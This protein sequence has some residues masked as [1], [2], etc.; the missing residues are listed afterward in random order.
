MAK[1]KITGHASGTGILTVTAPNTSTDRTITLPDATG[2]LIADD[3]SGNVGIGVTPESGWDSKF[4]VLEIAP[5]GIITSS[6]AA[7]DDVSYGYNWYENGGTAKYKESDYASIIEMRAGKQNFKVAPSGSADASITWTTAMTI[8][9]TGAVTKPLQPSFLVYQTV[10]QEISNA[11]QTTITFTTEVTDRNADYDGTSTFTAPVTGL[12]LF[13]A[14]VVTDA[15]A[16]SDTRFSDANLYFVASNRTLRIRTGENESSADDYIS[17][18]GSVLIDMDASDT[19]TVDAF[20]SRVGASGSTDTI[21]SSSQ[22]N[23][24]GHLVC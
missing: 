1:V 7:T 6:D 5:K 17:M 14:Q 15:G 13:T 23:F 20:Y 18:S 11:A 22:T 24:S 4:T 12:Y 2:T 9:S 3:G 10:S 16:S 19:I 21:A 8:D